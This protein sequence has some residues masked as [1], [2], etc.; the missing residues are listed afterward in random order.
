MLRDTNAL[1]NSNGFPVSHETHCYMTMEIKAEAKKEA[2]KIIKRHY[3]HVSGIH[4]IDIV[5]LHKGDLHVETARKC[6]IE[7]VKELLREHSC[8]TLI[9][10][11]WAFWAQ[12]EI[13]VK[14]I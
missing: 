13:E 11:R 2:F 1:I 10:K 14:G 6:A 5:S 9:D 4:E 3:A 7:T 12:V 8:E